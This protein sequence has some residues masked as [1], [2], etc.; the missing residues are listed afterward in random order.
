MRRFS[1]EDDARL[2]GM[3]HAGVST[4]RIMHTLERSKSSISTRLEVLQERGLL[5]RDRLM[6]Q[7][8]V[9]KTYLEIDTYNKV[10][11]AATARGMSVSRYIERTIKRLL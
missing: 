2:L 4:K 11:A 1:H 5:K 9:V 3:Y 6:G 8:K 7:R 10:A